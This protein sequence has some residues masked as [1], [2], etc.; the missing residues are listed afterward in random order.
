MVYNHL[1][2]FEISNLYQRLFLNLSLFHC[3]LCLL[4]NHFRVFHR[5]DLDYNIRNAKYSINQ[6]KS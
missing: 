4:A 6:L 3:F 5:Y 1:C 2:V